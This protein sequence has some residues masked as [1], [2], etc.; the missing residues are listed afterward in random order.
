MRIFRLFDSSV[1]TSPGAGST[2]AMQRLKSDIGLVHVQITSGTA[3]VKLQGRLNDGMP[4]STL[5]T[6][7]QTDMDSSESDSLMQAVR[8]AQEMRVNVVE[9]SSDPDIQVWIQE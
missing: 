4:W 3:L 6:F 5:A 8:L 2:Q 7:D 1:D 9:E